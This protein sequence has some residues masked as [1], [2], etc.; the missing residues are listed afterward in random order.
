MNK[1][2]YKNSQK[3]INKMAISTYLSIIT[4]NVTGVNAPIKRH[5]MAKKIRKNETHIYAACKR[6]TSD[7]KTHRER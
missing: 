1:E 6:L 2:D 7:L 3:P 4:L 5:R